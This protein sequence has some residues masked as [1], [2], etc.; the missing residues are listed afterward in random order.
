M[1]IKADPQ[2]PDSGINVYVVASV[3]R[4]S[5]LDRSVKFYRHVFSCRVVVREADMALLLTPKGFE[6]YLRQ[7]AGSRRHPEALGIQYLMWATDS[8][9]DLRR[10]AD[11]MRAYDSAMY[12]YTEDGMTILEGTDPDGFRMIVAY[13]T[14]RQLPHTAIA[15]RIRG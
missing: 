4:V 2:E 12:S 14:P 11:R 10:I 5:D 8:E 15:Q 1:N 6:I 13:P 7:T 3:A 9:S